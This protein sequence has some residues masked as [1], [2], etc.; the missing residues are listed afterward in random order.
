MFM[1]TLLANWELQRVPLQAVVYL[2]EEEIAGKQVLF[3]KDMAE[4]S[5]S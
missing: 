2:I 4:I 5:W 1:P 3:I